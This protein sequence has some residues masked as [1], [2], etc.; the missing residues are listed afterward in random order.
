VA[1]SGHERLVLLDEEGGQDVLESLRGK[2]RVT[3]VAS[4]RLVVVDD[5][6]GAREAALRAAPGVVAVSGPE[7]PAGLQKRLTD[8]EQL[9][10]DAWSQ[11]VTEGPRERPGEGLPWD[12]EG[13]EPPDAPPGS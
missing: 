10:A 4:P 2:F 3:H 11:R 12:A 5:V 13:F 9:F 7:L 8:G 6:D 1:A